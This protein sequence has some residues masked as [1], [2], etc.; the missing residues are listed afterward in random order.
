MEGRAPT[1][2]R[3]VPFHARRADQLLQFKLTRQVTRNRLF[4]PPVVETETTWRFVPHEHLSYRDRL[5]IY[6]E[7]CPVRMVEW[8]PLSIV[9]YSQSFIGCFVGQDWNIKNFIRRWPYVEDYFA[10]LQAKHEAER[11]RRIQREESVRNLKTV[12]LTQEPRP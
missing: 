2:Y 3:M 1:E 4:R 9:G 5:W 8:S 11:V 6:P 12:H 7:R 10:H